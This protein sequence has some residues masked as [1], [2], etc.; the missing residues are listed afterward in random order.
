MT[1]TKPL[2]QRI[3]QFYDTSS[4]LWER[5]WG[6]HMHHGYYGSNG[7]HRKDR[8]QA[9][10]DLI[11]ELLSWGNIT[12]AE[13]I[14][15]M[16]CGIGGSTLY[17]AKKYDANAVGIT[18]SPVQAQRAGERAAEQ[19][20]ALQAYENFEGSTSPAVQFQVTDALN[21][22]FPDNS[23]DFIW[24]MESGEHM[25]DKPGFLRECYRLLKPGGTF[26]MA[27]WC[28]RPTDTLAGPL[29]DGEQQHLDLLYDLY[30]L[31]YVISLKEYGKV[32]EDVGFSDIEMADW[33]RQVEFFWQ[34][35]VRSA[36]NINA[37]MG[38]FQAGMETVRGTAAIALMTT[39][40]DKGLIR[41]G[42]VKAT[43]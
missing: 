31:P 25:P 16:G 34:D 39:G 5:T 22:P 33:S 40:F 30:H 41:Y 18:L 2:S 1:A 19:G 23:F 38:I 3:Q 21:T 35:V 43:K 7:Q 36:L 20:I 28:H 10:I 13:T 29:T 12:T 27:T 37:V 14:L 42:I 26:L 9:Q 6:E 11:E 32:A 4:P 8:R 24:S 17:L 15:D